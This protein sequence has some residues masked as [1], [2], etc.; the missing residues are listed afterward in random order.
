MKPASA[1]HRVDGTAKALIAH[2][3]ALG[4]SYVSL[5]GVIDGALWFGAVVRLVDWKTPGKAELTEGQ[6][7]LLAQGC[8]IFFVSSPQQLE[9]VVADM[10][11]AALR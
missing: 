3:Q 1:R 2:A 11:R 8:P 10:R 9:S 7:K 5:G 4:A 6:G